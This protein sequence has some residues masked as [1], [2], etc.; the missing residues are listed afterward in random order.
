MLPDL[1]GPAGKEIYMKEALKQV[2]EL[3]HMP[4]SVGRCDSGAPK[5]PALRQR[6]NARALKFFLQVP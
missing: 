5:M 1:A 6:H 2:V 4:A 3:F